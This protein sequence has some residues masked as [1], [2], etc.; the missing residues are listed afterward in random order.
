[1]TDEQ[2]E[3]E[4]LR[5]VLAYDPETGA[6]TWAI[7]RQGTR[8][9][10]QPAGNVNQRLGY[11]Q[12]R[13]NGKLHYGHRIA[14]ALVTGRWPVLV[15]HI[16]GVKTD[17]RWANLRESDRRHN[18]ENRRRA[19]KNSKTD[20]LGVR[21]NRDRFGAALTVNHKTIHLGTYDTPEQAHAVYLD[22]KRMHHAGATI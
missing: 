6:I 7:E 19:N 13:A 18:Q 4:A 21:L 2:R 10:G 17:N 1:M 20:L 16:N 8:G 12:I 9:I 22:A 3:I 5:N 15:D 14:F 11:L